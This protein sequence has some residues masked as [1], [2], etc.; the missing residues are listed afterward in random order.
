VLLVS[1]PLFGALFTVDVFEDVT[2][3]R[4]RGNIIGLD[5]AGTSVR[6]NAS[7]A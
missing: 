4:I 1:T 5:A 2:S 7:G 6:G 3:S